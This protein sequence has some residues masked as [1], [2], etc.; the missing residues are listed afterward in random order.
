MVLH[1]VRLGRPRVR[2]AAAGSLL[3]LRQTITEQ[4][5]V[6]CN[7]PPPPISSRL[8]SSNRNTAL[9]NAH[10]LA[11]ITRLSG[12]VSGLHHFRLPQFDPRSP[13]RAVQSPLPSTAFAIGPL[14]T[15]VSAAHD[16]PTRLTYCSWLVT[17]A[18]SGSIGDQLIRHTYCSWL[19]T[20]ALNLRSQLS[21]SEWVPPPVLACHVVLSAHRFGTGS[22]RRT[23]GSLVRLVPRSWAPTSAL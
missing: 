2:S 15:S 21:T 7:L 4:V 20:A 8:L 3:C 23:S 19:V 22:P 13:Q 12:S 14:H 17:A 16:Q 9:L 6:A 1:G 10:V 18:H 11:F 5:G